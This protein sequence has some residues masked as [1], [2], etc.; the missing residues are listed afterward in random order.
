MLNHVC[1]KRI[2]WFLPGTARRNGCIHAVA[3]FCC[4]MSA[5]ERASLNNRWVML[6][7]PHPHLPHIS[8]KEVCNCIPSLHQSLCSILRAEQIYLQR[9]RS[10]PDNM[11]LTTRITT[12]VRLTPYDRKDVTTSLAHQVNDSSTKSMLP[13]W[14]L[15]RTASLTLS[16]KAP[17]PHTVTAMAPTRSCSSLSMMTCGFARPGNICTVALG[18]TTSRGLRGF[19]TKSKILTSSLRPGMARI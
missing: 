1:E 6:H 5:K 17:G 11:S 15:C 7:S 3:Q 16:A 8:G 4:S 14:S 10:G 12:P 2:V 9:P 13:T 18:L 19:V